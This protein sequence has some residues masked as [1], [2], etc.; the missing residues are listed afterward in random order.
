MRTGRNGLSRKDRVSGTGVKRLSR[1]DGPVKWANRP[2]LGQPYGVMWAHGKDGSDIIL[3]TDVSWRT[4]SGVVINT[5]W[6][7][8]WIY[9]RNWGTRWV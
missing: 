9:V 7:A 8:V 4:I 1:L 2:I 6:G 5:P 3:K